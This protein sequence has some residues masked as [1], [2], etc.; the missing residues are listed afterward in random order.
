MYISFNAKFE[1]R[2]HSCTLAT[3][4]HLETHQT[5]CEDFR[6][7][8]PPSWTVSTSMKADKR[9]W[10]WRENYPRL[11]KCWSRFILKTLARPPSRSGTGS[12][13]KYTFPLVQATTIVAT[14]EI[15]HHAVIDDV[16]I[17]PIL[18]LNFKTVLIKF[19]LQQTP[20]MLIWCTQTKVKYIK[21]DASPLRVEWVMYSGVTGQ[22]V[23]TT[24]EQ[25][26]GALYSLTRKIIKTLDLP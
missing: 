24:W 15:T 4:T 16:H 13:G 26:E 25:L 21:I 10:R 3:I 7:H 17:I 9:S 1:K 20:S 6:N 8:N 2:H 14:N 5:F 23:E 22:K 19:L 12:S 11:Q 18:I